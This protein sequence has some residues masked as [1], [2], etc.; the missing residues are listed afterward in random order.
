MKKTILLNIFILLGFVLSAQTLPDNW[1]GDSGIDTYQETTIVNTG[2]S[3]CRVD[4]KTASQASCDLTNDIIIP[5]T[6]GDTYTYTFWAY[7]SQYVRLRGILEW[8]GAALT[9]LGYIGP[10]TGGWLEFTAS[11]TVPTG[12]TGV[13]LRLRAYD[14]AGFTA[15]ETQ[16]VD[17][18]AFESPTG[19]VLTVVNGDMESWPTTVPPT[20]LVVTSV[21]GGSPPNINT[22][23]DVEVQAQ[24]DTNTPQSVSSNVD[25][26]LTLATGTGIL[27][28]TLTGTILAG[29]NTVTISGALYDV[30]EAG[31]SITASDDAAGLTA[32]TSA[33][34]EVLSGPV[35]IS[36]L[37]ELR[38]GTLG[39]EYTVTG[40]VVLTFQ[41]SFR[42]QKYIQD[43]TAAILI[44]D[45]G[46]IITST[47]AIGNGI[48]GITGTLGEYE[49]M[50]QFVPSSDPGAAT[51]SGNVI[52]PEVI[53]LND[54]TTNFENYESELVR[55]NGVSFADAGLLFANG[56]EYVISDASKAA[57]VFRTTFYYVDYIGD[58][59][60]AT[61][62]MIGLPNA[63]TEGN[64]ITS[65][66]SADLI[67]AGPNVMVKAYCT[68]FD[69]L[70][71]FYAQPLSSVDPFDYQ[72]TGS[73]T[74]TFSTA[75]ID[76]T[77]PTLVHLGGVSSNMIGDITLDNIYDD[78][79][80]TAYDFYAGIM[81][82]YYTNTNNPGGTMS[83]DIYATFF[84]IV[85]AND[86]YNNVWVSD[87]TGA[88]NGVLVFDYDFDN[89]VAV[90]DEIIFS[91]TRTVY[92]N[93]SE[94]K[95]ATFINISSSGNTPYGPAV[96]DGSDID[97]TLLPDTNPGESWEGQLVK[98]E[99]FTVES[100]DAANFNYRCSWT[101]GGPTYYFQIG[102]NV[103]FEFG[104]I[105]LTVGSSY[106][107]ITGVV[108]WDYTNSFYRVNPRTQV[109]VEASP[110]NPPTQLAI[111]SV[112]GGVN[113]YADANFDVHVQAQDAGGVPAIVT[114]DVNFTFST[115]DP[116]NV[117]FTALSTLTGTILMGTSEIIVTGVQMAPAGTGVSITAND[118]N[119]FGLADG[120][121]GLFDVIELTL[122]DI[123]ITEIMQNPDSASDSYG[124]WFEV[125]NNSGSDVD[126]IGY[127][128][129]DD[130][131][132]SHIIASS[133]IVPANGFAVL[134]I[135]D[136]PLLNGGYTCDYVYSGFF[137]ANG[138][139]EVVIYL[140]D[141][142]TEVD[143]V[144][145]DGGAVWPDPH[146]ASMAFT[147]FPGEDNNDGTTWTWTVFRESTFLAGPQDKGSP[148]T[149]GYSQILTGGFK[150]DLTL[151]LEG[152]F[153]S[154]NDSMINGL[155]AAGVMPFDQPFNP[156]LPY[157]G[158]N[159][160]AWLY[161]GTEDL[162]HVQY[163]A[164]DW[165]LIELR[166]ASTAAGATPGTVVAQ[167]PAFVMDDGTVVS[168]NGTHALNINQTFTNDMYVV[169]W[170]RNHLSIMNPTGL[171]PVDGTTVSYDFSS[172]EGQVYG[173]AAG[174]KML[175]AGIWGM[176]SGDSNG[177][178]VINAT[179]KTAAW[180]TEA[181][182][183][184]YKGYDLN[185]DGEV[186]NIDKNDF[187]VPNESA[188]SQV[189]N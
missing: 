153:N 1:T 63:R 137:L 17:D 157:Y 116:L 29:T 2:L 127:V 81:P 120:T 183:A 119:P 3:S 76:G 99:N 110:T 154:S 8:E 14:V 18:F 56:T 30:A 167:Y 147:G 20:K 22:A 13:K 121:S 149:N 4:V 146:G 89:L 91:G 106:L 144:N 107:S 175:K 136:D 40:E 113:P 159:T 5:V 129:A 67:A 11:G 160:P 27:S 15:P 173:A 115:N 33:P 48:T 28:G 176:F 55:V 68:S 171:T 143:R 65:R 49:N 72:L 177:D 131:T 26:T 135:N 86:G 39:Y 52:T 19:T 165:L 69:A 10:E 38:A 62:D 82:I 161:G 109:D 80:G 174:H 42:N 51:S 134:G 145:Y 7:T 73:I 21:N 179:D 96:I 186:N 140:P 123:I 44:D 170:H 126:M 87:A 168:M 103:N 64:F 180:D 124:E 60:P 47:Y 187:W 31:V 97:E 114:G 6:V 189:P 50:M 117:D 150:L 162:V 141:G 188:S 66:S 125:Y 43:A 61:V 58:P 112:N 104:T 152:A 79:I 128:I 164:I 151:F 133:L 163:Y 101:N 184:G 138:D 142:V 12:A 45:N 53:S 24:D 122:P 34:F 100:F 35:V 148:G 71:V 156:G 74:I 83:D 46:G 93:L 95:N 90:G 41:Q 166:D 57:A 182:E 94:I 32:G 59:I 98:I 178:Q 139:D 25:V 132:N 185:L 105:T 181:G 172:G 23:F 77:D 85:S 111:V 130:G 108:D 70:D 118:D 37:A 158:N 102:D 155:R 16:Y 92:S 75:V 36:T 78:G 9:Y 84:G 88:Y 169:V 54:L